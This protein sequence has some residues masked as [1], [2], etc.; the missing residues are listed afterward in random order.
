MSSASGNQNKPGRPRQNRSKQVQ[1][2][3]KVVFKYSK[4]SQ[5]S[6]LALS[7]SRKELTDAED[8]IRKAKSFSRSRNRGLLPRSADLIVKQMVLPGDVADPV[9]SPQYSSMASTVLKFSFNYD[10][11]ASNIHAG[12][13]RVFVTPDVGE[14][15]VTDTNASLLY[16]SPVGQNYAFRMLSSGDGTLA[17]HP[18]TSKSQ[19]YV[20][21]EV[22]FSIG[23]SQS[24]KIRALQMVT[25]AASTQTFIYESEHVSR[26]YV[27]TSADNGNTWAD[28]AF[29]DNLGNGDWWWGKS[30]RNG[31]I[32]AGTDYIYFEVKGKSGSVVP[33]DLI[34]KTTTAANNTIQFTSDHESCVFNRGQ[35][36][37]D[38]QEVKQVQLI[39]MSALMTNTSANLEK[40]GTMR[41]ALNP[42]QQGPLLE[43]DF[44]PLV[45]SRKYIGPAAKG[46][47]CWWQ[48]RN[49][50]VDKLLPISEAQALYRDEDAIN[51]H[52]TGLNADTSFALEVNWIVRVFS[53]KQLF[54]KSLAPP[55]DDRY[56]LLLQYMSH[57]H[58]C[59][60]NPDHIQL[61]KDILRKGASA[62][63]TAYE[64]YQSNPAFFNEM[65]TTLLGLLA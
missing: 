39:G 8:V 23:G 60:C 9:H 58:H 24:R 22:D 37:L 30:A 33:G 20:G 31:V 3:E 55:V 54:T 61:F 21:K 19:V 51:F 28:M 38:T 42:F 57:M 46:G 7:R 43:N 29:A 14:V 41:V 27:Y 26:I 62:F 63:K 64:V 16:P 59:S 48:S 53:E 25:G 65:G 15:F 47:Y 18:E 35:D 44:A 45:V 1:P 32:P 56:L 52:A 2:K 4:A 10:I 11:K 6:Q 17:G 34:M 13:C 5:D 50:V 40:Q 36:F 49:P 12:K